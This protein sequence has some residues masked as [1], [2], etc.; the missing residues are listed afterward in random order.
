MGMTKDDMLTEIAKLSPG[1]F[2]GDISRSE[3]YPFLENA[4]LA[5]LNRLY[6]YD[7]TKTDVPEKYEYLQMQIAIYLINKVGAEGE[8]NHTE[9]GV[10]R[11]YGSS[12][13]PESYLKEIVPRA[14][15]IK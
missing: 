10:S 6:P 5:I 4:K 8:S 2:D 13:I 7:D 11:T 9:G 15:V 14:G 3:A 1:I 12:G